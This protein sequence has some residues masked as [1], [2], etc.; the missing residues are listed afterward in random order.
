MKKTVV[1]FTTLFILIVNTFGHPTGQYTQQD[2]S[3][4]RHWNID[5]NGQQV[6]GNFLMSKNDVV[7]IEGI[8]GKIWN[9]NLAAL[10]GDDRN[11]VDEKIAGIQSLN[12]TN[13]NVYTPQFPGTYNYFWL[14]MLGL[15]AIG[16]Y[17]LAYYTQ[18]IKAAVSWRLAFSGLTTA[19]MVLFVISCKKTVVPTPSGN[20][21]SGIP[22][23]STGFIDSAFTPYKPAIATGWDTTY[24]YVASNGIPNHNMMVG[25]TSWQQQVPVI[26]NYTGTN[27]WSIPLQ[28]V[29]ATTPLSTRTNLMRGAVAIAANGIP[30]FNALNNRGEDAF[31]IGELDQWGGH[32]GKGDDYHYHAAPLSLSST[33]GLKPIAFALDGFA[34]YGAKEPDGSNMQALDTCHGHIYNNG[35][36][37]YHG[38]TTYPYVVGAMKGKVT[39]DPASTAPENQILPQAFTSPIRPPL[40]PLRGAVITGFT[41]PAANTY[42]LTYQIGSRL[43]HVNYTWDNARHYHFEFIDTAGVTTIANY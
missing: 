7:F 39:I 28:P 10:S 20:G 11:Y 40:T 35:V 2:L 12:Y 14:C 34:V 30:I 16:F 9:V 42:N 38:T 41:A 1:L 32:C 24:F 5:I 19:C 27:R 21:G 15:G 23:T 17:A 6:I 3:L 13:R 29:Y 18:K 4:L 26:Q 8:N 25:I 22:K 36:Y 33:S 43:G 31:M 37:H